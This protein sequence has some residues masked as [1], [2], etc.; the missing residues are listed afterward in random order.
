MLRPTEWRIPARQLKPKQRVVLFQRQCRLSSWF[1][2]QSKMRGENRISCPTVSHFSPS[3]LRRENKLKTCA[4]D[5]NCEALCAEQPPKLWQTQYLLGHELFQGWCMWVCGGGRGSA[6]LE[7][8][9]IYFFLTLENE[10]CISPFG[11]ILGLL[12]H[13]SFM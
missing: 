5:N 6:F 12:P 13:P 10:K 8:S 11:L 7:F 3:F 9:T 1:L 4:S 2:T